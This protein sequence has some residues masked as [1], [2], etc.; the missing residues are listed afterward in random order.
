MQTLG[1]NVRSR[2]DGIV[3]VSAADQE[4][5]DRASVATELDLVVRACV[6]ASASALDLVSSTLE[7]AGLA[8]SVLQRTQTDVGALT[9]RVRK[10]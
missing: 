2:D 7:S 5:L 6:L 1:P 8:F 9:L 10:T 3:E 4:R